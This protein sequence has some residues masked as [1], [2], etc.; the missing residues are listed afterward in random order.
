MASTLDPA[1]IIKTFRMKPNPEGGWYAESYRDDSYKESRGRSS[2]IYFLLTKDNSSRWHR[3]KDSV[4]IW[5][6]YAGSP[7]LLQM[8][9]DGGDVVKKRLGPNL[10]TG[11]RPQVAV[12]AGWWQTAESLGDWTLVG[13]TVTPGFDPEQFELAEIERM[14]TD[15]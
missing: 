11:E 6:F 14:I 4:E 7:V 1:A 9:P 8:N 15:G 2:A 13:C 10:P 5:H 3:L 12:P